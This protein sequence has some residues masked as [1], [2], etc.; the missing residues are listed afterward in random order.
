VLSI[1]VKLALSM[2]TMTSTTAAEAAVQLLRE[3]V[4][5]LGLRAK[6]SVMSR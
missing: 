1:P 3:K 5:G 6:V 4:R 2:G